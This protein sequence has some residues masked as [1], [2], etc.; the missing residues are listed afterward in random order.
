MSK[1]ELTPKDVM[2]DAFSHKENPY[3][4]GSSMVV[5][6]RPGALVVFNRKSSLIVMWHMIGE[7]VEKL[8]VPIP[9]TAY[10]EAQ[11]EISA[12]TNPALSKWWD[13]M[14]TLVESEDLDLCN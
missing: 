12:D 8:R 1:N 10:M 6:H 7:V 4:S 5:Y 13:T 11:V 2:R 14:L 3:V 9:T